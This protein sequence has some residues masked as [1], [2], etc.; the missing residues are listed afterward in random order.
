MMWTM[1]RSVED[2]QLEVPAEPTAV[3]TL[4]DAARDVVTNAIAQ[5]PDPERLALWL[6]VRGVVDGAFV[7]DLYFQ[8]LSD[9]ADDD[10]VFSDQDLPVVVPA[11]SIDVLRGARLE[12]SEE[13]TG[14]LVL[15]NPNTPPQPA[16]SG[17]PDEVLAAGITGPLAVRAASVLE[18]VVNPSIASHGGRADLVAMD[19]ENNVAYLRLSGGCPGCAMSRMTLTQGI[20]T[21][22]RD[23]MP[24]L[25]G[26]IDV[27]DHDAGENPYA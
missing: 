2:L 4:T 7:Y 22:L 13:G 16:P 3:V 27:T 24:E 21:A 15:V 18:S 10:A 26:V 6:E 12:W 14:G 1:A 5:E 9:A 19:E 17:V 8:A 23:E 11:T 25:T 20:E